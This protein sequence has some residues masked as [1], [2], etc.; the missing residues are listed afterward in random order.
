MEVIF[1]GACWWSHCHFPQGPLRGRP[2]G[3]GGDGVGGQPGERPQQ[4]NQ[5]GAAEDTAEVPPL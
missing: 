3:H 1:V 4:A 2:G 5:H